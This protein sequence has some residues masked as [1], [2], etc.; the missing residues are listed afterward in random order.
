MKQRCLVV[1]IDHR[2]LGRKEAERHQR[3]V[4][5]SIALTHAQQEFAIVFGI[6]SGGFA[7]G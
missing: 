7:L 4:H 6:S 3:G 1:F 5:A 2:S